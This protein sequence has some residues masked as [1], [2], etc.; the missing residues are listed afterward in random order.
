MTDV[1]SVCRIEVVIVIEEECFYFFCCWKDGKNQ[2]YVIIS[3]YNDQS[4]SKSRIFDYITAGEGL[5]ISHLHYPPKNKVNIQTL[6]NGTFVG[7]NRY[8][9]FQYP[10]LTL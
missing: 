5:I 1:I 8:H 6:Q 10:R 3:S 2:R 4:G 7:L 9:R